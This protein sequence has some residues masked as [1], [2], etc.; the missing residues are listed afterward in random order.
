MNRMF[1]VRS[2][3]VPCPQPSTRVLRVRTACAAA[4][5]RPP[6]FQPA[7]RPAWHAPLSTR[8]AFNQ[9]GSTFNQL[10]SFDTSSVTHMSYMFY[11]RSARA[12]APAALSRAIPV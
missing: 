11:V 10:L 7:P 1:E 5:P 4:A 3:P 2:E 8:Q 6:A 12:L 9:R